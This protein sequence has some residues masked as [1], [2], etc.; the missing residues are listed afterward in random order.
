M[1][2]DDICVLVTSPVSSFWCIPI[3]THT[4]NTYTH[5]HSNS[6]TLK[7]TH[8]QTHT[9]SNSTHSHTHTHI[10][11]HTHTHTHTHARTHALAH[12]HTSRTHPQHTHVFSPKVTEGNSTPARPLHLTRSV[13]IRHIPPKISAEDIVEVCE[14][15][16]HNCVYKSL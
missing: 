16:L 5:T 8:T 10:H 11:T 3:C 6:H 7:L 14:C 1:C 9:H 12:S 2:V 4:R 15:F 13:Y